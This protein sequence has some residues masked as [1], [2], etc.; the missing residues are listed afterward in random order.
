MDLLAPIKIGA[1]S[2][3]P[4]KQKDKSE[5]AVIFETLWESAQ[6]GELLLV[7]GGLKRY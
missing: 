5:V 7:N 1:S 4:G 2:R 6:R 3:E